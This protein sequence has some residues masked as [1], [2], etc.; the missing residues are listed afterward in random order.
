MTDTAQPI[1]RILLKNVR[2][3]FA[4]GLFEASTIPGAPA[5]AKPK[6]NCGLIITA[7]HPQLAEIREKQKAVAAAKW[8]GTDPKTKRP[9]WEA[10]YTQLDKAD[11]LALHD[12]DTKPNYDGYPGNFFLSP[13]AQE[14]SRPTV[15]DQLRQPLDAKSGKPYSGCYVNCSVELWAQDNGFGKRVNAQLRGVQFLRDGD[16]FGAGRPADSNEFEELSEGSDASD[17]A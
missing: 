14:N 5:D 10:V 4:Q 3:S 17:F 13:S 16:A 12:G 15:V 9:V 7:D 6:F 2:L 8:T 1:G 11:K